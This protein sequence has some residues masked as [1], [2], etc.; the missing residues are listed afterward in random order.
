[1]PF[2]DVKFSIDLWQLAALML[3]AYSLGKHRSV[4]LLERIIDVT[5][6]RHESRRPPPPSDERE[7]ETPRDNPRTRRITR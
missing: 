4:Q 2:A 6:N 5:L 1:M 7:D 3:L